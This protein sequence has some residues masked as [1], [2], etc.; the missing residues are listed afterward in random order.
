MGG[1]EEAIKHAAT[2]GKTKSYQTENYPEY[3]RNSED[4][5]KGLTGISMFQSKEELLKEQIGEEGYQLLE[6]IKRV[7]QLKG[8]Q[9]R[10]PFELKIK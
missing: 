7:N 9:A 4:L 6:Q 5:L 3:K 1:L 10:M 8:T 2:L